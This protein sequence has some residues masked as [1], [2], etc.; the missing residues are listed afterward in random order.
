MTNVQFG[1]ADETVDVT[2]PAMS[3]TVASTATT[4]PASGTRRIAV[5]FM[6]SANQVTLSIKPAVIAQESRQERLTR[7]IRLGFPPESMSTKG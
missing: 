5:S 6:S 3:A 1:S 2:V 7:T 4:N